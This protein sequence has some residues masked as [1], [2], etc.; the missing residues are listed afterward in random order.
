MPLYEFRC[1]G[2]GPLERSFAMAEV[3]QSISCPQCSL[4]SK[5]VV[6]SPRLTHSSSTAMGLLDSTA[7][8]AHEPA[9]VSGS[10]PGRGRQSAPTTSNPLHRKL[11]RP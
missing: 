5:R 11:P 2:C 1:T 4:E 10:L 3:P 9:V 7:R 8:S 6:S